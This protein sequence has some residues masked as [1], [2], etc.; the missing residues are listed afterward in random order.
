L[1]EA[2][3]PHRGIA[4]REIAAKLTH[5]YGAHKRRPAALAQDAAVLMLVAMDDTMLLLR[6]ALSDYRDAHPAAAATAAEFLRFLESGPDVFERTH[7]IGHF[8]GSAWLVDRSGERVLLTHHRKLNAWLQ[9]GGHADGD[10]DLSRVALREAEEESGLARLVVE[11]TIFDIDRHRIPARAGEPEHWHYDVRYVV[12]ATQGEEFVV[13]EESH[14]LAWRRM[15]E[16]VDDE[17]AD[18]SIRRMARKWLAR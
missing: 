15:P 13:G 1:K 2:R 6:E 11:P 9:L 18:A 5:G 17:T 14:A 8:T 4:A 10:A 16:L 12:R 3:L 7:A